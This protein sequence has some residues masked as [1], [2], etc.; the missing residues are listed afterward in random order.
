[1][2]AACGMLNAPE[3]EG[4]LT[5]SLQK[6]APSARDHPALCLASTVSVAMQQ[7]RLGNSPH[8]SNAGRTGGA[9]LKGY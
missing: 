9:K 8:G 3:R 6:A 2:H 4:E 7:R 5:F 1:M